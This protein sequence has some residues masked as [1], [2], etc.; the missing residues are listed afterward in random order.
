MRAVAAVRQS[1]AGAALA[2]R[3]AGA[4]R[5]LHPHTGPQSGACGQGACGDS[6]LRQNVAATAGT[7]TA[8]TA[9]AGTATASV[10]LSRRTPSCQHWQR[11]TNLSQATNSEIEH[12][13]AG[14]S[15]LALC[16]A[17]T[18]HG[19]RRRA[20]GACFGAVQSLSLLRPFGVC[21]EQAAATGRTIF[22]GR[23]WLLRGRHVQWRW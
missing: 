5:R 4:A 17:V 9:T 3:Q 7:A 1:A 23:G 13:D 10:S 16:D 8:G 11:L 18:V 21:R 6:F 2:T 12:S 14:D 15:A 22:S 19:W 20:L